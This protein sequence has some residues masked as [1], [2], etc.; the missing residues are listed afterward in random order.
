MFQIIS[1]RTRALEI[2]KKLLEL[3]KSSNTVPSVEPVLP[4]VAIEADDPY[5]RM[6]AKGDR[7]RSS[8][9]DIRKPFE[10]LIT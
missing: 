8:C 6:L 9:S 1:A 3:E 7:Q 5:E 4:E 10:K 2:G